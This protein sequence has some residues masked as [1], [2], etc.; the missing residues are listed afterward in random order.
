[1]RKGGEK[2]KKKF[3]LIFLFL[4][5]FCGGVSSL[6][7]PAPVRTAGELRRSHQ[8]KHIQWCIVTLLLQKYLFLIGFFYFFNVLAIFAHVMCVW[9]LYLAE[10]AHVRPDVFFLARASRLP[11]E[12]AGHSIGPTLQRRKQASR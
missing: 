10:S 6:P 1:M 3:G 4:W 11:A 2:E 12:R 5:F 7:R 9:W 8:L